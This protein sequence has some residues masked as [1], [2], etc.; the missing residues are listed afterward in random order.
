MACACVAAAVSWLA[1]GGGFV[2]AAA[3]LEG[4]RGELG[5]EAQA[6]SWP[7]AELDR[8]E[9]GGVFVD[10]GAVEAEMPSELLGRQQPCGRRVSLLL[11]F[12]GW[13]LL[14]AEELRDALRDL[15]D[16]VG[17]QLGGGASGPCPAPGRCVGSGVGR[18]DRCGWGVSGGFAL[19]LFILLLW[20]PCRQG[21]LALPT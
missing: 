6:W 18:L 20:L 11:D 21:F 3:G 16:R 5:V 13:R 17:G 9:L 19:G 2:A 10:P 1:R 15:L 8:A 4:L 14:V 12:G 7:V